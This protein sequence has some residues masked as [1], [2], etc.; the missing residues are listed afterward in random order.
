M[1][2]ITTV[3]S[4]TFAVEILDDHRVSVDGK[5]YQVDFTMIGDQPVYSLLINGSSVEAHVVPQEESWHILLRGKMYDARVED[6]RAK[7]ARAIPGASQA[8][9]AEYYLKAPM[10]GLVVAIPM[11][12]GQRVEKDATLIVLESMK[13]QN[14]L[15]SPRAGVVRE[16][17]VHIGQAVE[18]K[19]VLVVV[20]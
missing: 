12:A 20:E 9:T 11:E 19:Q 2:Y 7:H 18:Q 1:K 14:E 16:V 15:R 3:D 5:E 10:P 13:M 17:H 4:K 6:E 8:E